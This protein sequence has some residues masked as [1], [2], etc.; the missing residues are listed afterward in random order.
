MLSICDVSRA[1]SGVILLHLASLEKHRLNRLSR[2]RRG[3]RL[4]QALQCAAS[5]CALIPLGS[6][7]AAAQPAP[8]FIMKMGTASINDQQ[9]EWLKL[10]KAAVEHDSGGRIR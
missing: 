1:A 7:P 10:Y 4:L 9:H 5:I 8:A 6:L 2:M 3:K